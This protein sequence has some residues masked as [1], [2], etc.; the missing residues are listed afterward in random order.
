MC[1]SALPILETCK[2]VAGYYPHFQ[3]I[4]KK[5]KHS[6]QYPSPATVLLFLTVKHP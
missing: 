6:T 4:I 1:L 5:K 3:Q 2:Q